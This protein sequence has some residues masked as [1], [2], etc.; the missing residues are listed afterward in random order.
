MDTDAGFDRAAICDVQSAGE[1]AW[2]IRPM[3][4]VRRAV[5]L[6]YGFDAVGVRFGQR[7]GLIA[8]MSAD[9]V[10]EFSNVDSKVFFEQADA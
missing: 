1:V 9:V 3:Y 6:L 4:K 5:G 7:E 8:Q 10:L 2:R